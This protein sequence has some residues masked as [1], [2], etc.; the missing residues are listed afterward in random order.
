MHVLTLHALHPRFSAI[1]LIISPLVH[2]LPRQVSSRDPSMVHNF[3]EI[4]DISLPFERKMVLFKK[5]CFV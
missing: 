2:K 3:S 1:E 4:L 5:I